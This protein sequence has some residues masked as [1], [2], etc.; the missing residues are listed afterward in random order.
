MKAQ[1]A[2]LVLLAVAGFCNVAGAGSVL[3]AQAQNI[4][5][6]VDRTERKVK[7]L[8]NTKAPAWASARYRSACQHVARKAGEVY[9]CCKSVKLYAQKIV[10]GDESQETIDT[11]G[12]LLHK[13]ALAVNAFEEA[14]EELEEAA[15]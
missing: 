10:N 15:K 5:A 4:V 6:D 11:L 7:P 8:L 13:L 14:V 1:T 3:T 9:A 12:K 2:F